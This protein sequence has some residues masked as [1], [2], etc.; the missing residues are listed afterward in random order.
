MGAIRQALLLLIETLFD[1]YIGIV[2]LRFIFQCFRLDFYNPFSQALVKATNPILVPLRR[3]I[4]GYG[5]LDLSSVILLLLLK[6]TELLLIYFIKLATIPN[7]VGIVLL[8]ISAL[9]AQTINIFFFSILIVVLFSWINPH[10]L[11]G[12]LGSLISQ[13]IQPIMRPARKLIPPMGGIDVSPIIAML[14]L[15]LSNIL[16][17]TPLQDLAFNNLK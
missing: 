2:L 8:S 6:V 16:L 14:I 17:I 1:L 15:Q 10:G 7:I 3:Y 12:P 11:Q 5:G 9:L 4:P 13:L